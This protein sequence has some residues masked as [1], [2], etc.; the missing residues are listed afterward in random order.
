MLTTLRRAEYAELIALFFLHAAAM[1]MWFVP[2]SSVLAAHG[3]A[4]I[5]PYAFATS[6]V[7]AFVSPLLFG[8]MAD[9]HASPV[10]VLRWLAFATALTMAAACA[11]IQTGAGAWTV[12]ALIQIYAFCASPTWSIGSTIVFA[13]LSDAKKEFGPIRSMATLGWSAGCLLVSVLGA[14]QST[15]A[16]YGAAGMWLAVWGLTF[17]LPALATP[18]AAE[19]L[20][21]A[22]RFGLDALALLKN[23]DHRMVFLTPAL[24]TIPIAG[25]YPY[26]PPH[27]RELG[28]VHTSAWMSLGQITEI[29][30]MIALGAM[31]ARWRLKWIVAAGLAIG[32][33][34]FALCATGT[35]WGLLA[36]IILHGG[37]FTLVY[38]TAQIYLDQRID[39]AW[40]ARAQALM[41]LMNSGFG[42]L[43]GYLGT[44]AWFAV[45][46]QRGESR[47]PLFWIGLS[48]ASLAVLALFLT[49][50]R[51][52]GVP[53]TASARLPST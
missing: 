35:K 37:S 44:G 49:A 6:G 4:H 36:G 1:S 31:I 38:I 10:V 15:L 50:Y 21:W 25:F 41:T 23:R 39:H 42:N 43:A 14:D 32:A 48:L 52:R 27:L 22:Q 2:L 9:R 30:A 24:F 53:P 34:R 12:L 16:G 46:A 20:T 45:C 17:W 5:Q 51:G 26:T 33:I 47:W 3:L 7:A 8:A 40:R 29:A 11:A 28:F 18:K 13:R 19:G